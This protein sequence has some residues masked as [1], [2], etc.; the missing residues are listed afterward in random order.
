MFEGFMK[1]LLWVI[2]VCNKGCAENDVFIGVV[3]LLSMGIEMQQMV[4]IMY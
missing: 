2:G 4:A 3:A 1:M